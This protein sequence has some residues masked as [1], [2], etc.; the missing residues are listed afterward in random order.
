VTKHAKVSDAGSY[1]LPSELLSRKGWRPGTELEVEETA[2]G[3]TIRAVEPAAPP[4]FDYE[5][6]RR[7]VPKHEGPPATLEDMQRGIDQAMAERWAR[8]EANSR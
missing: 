1:E 6:F 5:A 4:G 2:D 7:R 8:K 3:F